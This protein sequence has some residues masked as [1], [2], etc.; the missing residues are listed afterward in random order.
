MKVI[1]D[2]Y[3]TE[4][5]NSMQS[6]D[7]YLPETDGFKVFLYIHGGGL[8]AGSKALGEPFCRAMT[9]SGIAVVSIEYRMYPNAKYPDFIEDAASAVAWVQN[10]MVLSGKYGK[11]NGLYVGGS[12]AGGYL[13]MMLCFD[14]R[15]LAAHGLDNSVISGYIHD[16]GQPTAHFKVLENSGYDSRRVIIDETAPLYFVGVE[17]EYPPMLFI[18]SDNDMVNRP[19]QTEVM[20][21]ALRHFG[22]D[23]STIRV[24]R[25]HGNHCEY[26]GKLDE[27]GESV[28]SG[29]LIPFIREF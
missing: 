3:Y 6:L 1:K 7:I 13:T 27:N 21:T 25:V 15:Y 2:I 17:K 20:L 12:S 10:N 8:T 5:R 11:C 19:E 22:Y 9:D 28:F 24:L 14:R 23:Q 26:C 29:M 4:S 18:I 16:A